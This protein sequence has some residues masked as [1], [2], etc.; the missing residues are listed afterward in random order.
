VQNLVS[1]SRV[2]Q[3]KLLARTALRPV[4]TQRAGG[5]LAGA[6]PLSTASPRPALNGPG[7]RPAE[8]R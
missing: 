3:P 8:V 1:S 7:R 2:T 4:L 5:R 6:G